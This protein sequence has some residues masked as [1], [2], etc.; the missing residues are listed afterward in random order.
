MTDFQILA[1]TIAAIDL[2]KKFWDV[3]E[4]YGSE[5]W[6]AGL[7]NADYDHSQ[8]HTSY[9]GKIYLGETIYQ[10]FAGYDSHT[11]AIEWNLSIEISEDFCKSTCQNRYMY[12]YTPF[13]LSWPNYFEKSTTNPAEIPQLAQEAANLLISELITL[14]REGRLRTVWQ[15]AWDESNR[16]RREYEAQIG[17]VPP[18]F[19][20]RQDS[21]QGDPNA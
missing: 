8:S 15:E 14:R 10:M 18:V 13:C 4:E 17:F 21:L 5:R 19:H 3:Y 1:D 7:E 12:P 11:Q 6:S 16:R 2:H 9:D 20:N